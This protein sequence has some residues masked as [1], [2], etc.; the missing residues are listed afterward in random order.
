MSPVGRA[1]IVAIFVAPGAL[2]FEDLSARRR[3]IGFDLAEHLGWPFGRVEIIGQPLEVMHVLDRDG[4]LEERGAFRI[5]LHGRAR[6]KGL[7]E[8]AL[9]HRVGVDGPFD[10][11]IILE[12]PD[13]REVLGLIA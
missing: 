10:P 3:Q 12:T 6:A 11:V 9:H 4:G 1:S 5:E 8:I 2:F 7:G 13:A